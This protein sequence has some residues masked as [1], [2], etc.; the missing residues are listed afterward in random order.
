[1]EKGVVPMTEFSETGL[2]HSIIRTL[3]NFSLHK[4]NHI[5]DYEQVNV[6]GKI[7]QIVGSYINYI[8]RKN[9]YKI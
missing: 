7:A 6:S 4:K 1:M 8:N 2:Y 3:N 5:Q 9:F